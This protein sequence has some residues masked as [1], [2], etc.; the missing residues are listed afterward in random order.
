MKHSHHLCGQKQNAASYWQRQD[1]PRTGDGSL[2]VRWQRERCHDAEEVGSI[3]FAHTDKGTEGQ[4]ETAAFELK[5]NKKFE[6][7]CWLT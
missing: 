4:S 1:Q 7:R 5:G 6:S 2:L 3:G